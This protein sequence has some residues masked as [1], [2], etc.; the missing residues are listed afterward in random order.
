[1]PEEELVQKALDP[2]V[3]C[4][5]FFGGSPEP[6]FPFVLKAAER[7]HRESGG[8]KHI[9]WEWNGC[10]NRSYVRKA[11]DLSKESGGTV[12]FDLKAYHPK[13]SY[14]LCGVDNKKAYKNFRFVALVGTHG[15]ILAI[16]S[17]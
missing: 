14:A 7:I 5:C 17:R 6:Q 2:R 1:M 9:C 8:K 16:S 10:G 12:K 3:R 13:I 15:L 11:A 4:V